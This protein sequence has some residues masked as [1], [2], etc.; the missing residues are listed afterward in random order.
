MSP[1]PAGRSD[2]TPPPES[3]EKIDWDRVAGREGNRSWRLWV[4]ALGFVIIAAGFYF[5]YVLGESLP[6]I[7]GME[8]LDWLFAV[9]CLAIGVFVVAPLAMHPD[10]TARYWRRLR[11]HPTGVPSLL[12][13]L[14]FFAVGLV[15]PAVVSEPTGI[16][17]DR[18]YQPPVWTSIDTVYLFTEDACV[19]RIADGR[20]HG[21]LRHPLGTTH[22][23]KDLLPIVL[24][25]ARTSL[26]V[27][28]VS[29]TLIV[30][31]G[32]G[33]GIISAYAGGRTDRFLMQVAEVSQTV[34][35]II[36]YMLFWGWNA[37]YRL[38]V[39]IGVFGVTSWGG[40]A[41]IVRNEA[42]Q[43]RE[44]PYVKAARGAGAGK[45]TIMRRHLLPNISRSVLT[46]VTLQIP[47]LVVTEAAL[48]YIILP[49]P[50]DGEPVTL[51]DP[52]VI[53][54]GQTINLGTTEAGLVPGWWIAVIPSALLV[55]TMLAFALFGRT[56]GDVLDPQ[57]NT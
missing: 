56:L 16:A 23:G 33:I 51:G 10:E 41:R 43:L 30:P 20:C 40:L 25:G 18:S 55:L 45:L 52:T 3:F 2:V 37:E 15:A 38:L 5:D 24:L 13:I 46:N 21:T 29:A 35:A 7:D 26:L 31:T 22:D 6:L 8:P 34:P 32:V 44:R 42:L 12:V 11:Q 57:P 9:S 17:F 49:S 14:G 39:L 4:F 48:S 36:I 28:V 19:G 54:W 27:A 50:F 47:L 53:S 1:P